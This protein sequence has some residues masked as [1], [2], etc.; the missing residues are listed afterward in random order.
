[1][2]AQILNRIIASTLIAS[3]AVA[4][5]GC[6]RDD[7]APGFEDRPIEPAPA[8]PPAVPPAPG[9]PPGGLPDAQ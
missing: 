3:F 5:A 9:N 2:R 1:M 7:D 8:V 6:G 4:L